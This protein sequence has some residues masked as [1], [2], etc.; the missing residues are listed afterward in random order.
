MKQLRYY[1]HNADNI[2]HCPLHSSSGDLGQLWE[3]RF[4]QI[5]SHGYWTRKIFYWE[6][7]IQNITQLLPAKRKKS[8]EELIKEWSCCATVWSPFG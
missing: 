3:R 1:N 4:V 8:Y 5:E 7:W 6:P 2:F